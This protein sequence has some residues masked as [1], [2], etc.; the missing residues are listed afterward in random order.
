MEVCLCEDSHPLTFQAKYPTAEAGAPF[1]INAA[2]WE[3]SVASAGCQVLAVAL[4]QAVLRP[5]DLEGLCPGDTFTV[6]ELIQ[7][8]MEVGAAARAEVAGNWYASTSCCY[9]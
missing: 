5:E 6:P 9:N 7:R 2:S 4:Q 3:A 8:R 1:R